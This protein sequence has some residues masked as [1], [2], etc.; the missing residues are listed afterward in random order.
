MKSSPMQVIE[1]TITKI[2]ALREI[3][4]PDDNIVMWGEPFDPKELFNKVFTQQTTRFKPNGVWYACGFD[5]LDWVLSD[6]PKWASPYIYNLKVDKSNFKI[7][8]TSDELIEFSK[9]Y[10]LGDYT[11]STQVDWPR[12]AMSYN[13][14]EICPYQWSLRMRLMWFYPWDVASGCIWNTITIKAVDEIMIP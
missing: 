2:E 5:W 10:V 3:V 7:I 9:E 8:R 4:R 13:G 11:H 12:L 6:M 1:S 14:I